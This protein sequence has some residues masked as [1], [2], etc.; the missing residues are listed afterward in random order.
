MNL[1]GRI[2]WET[3]H[4]NCHSEIVVD[5]DYMDGWRAR[6]NL[7]TAIDVWNIQTFVTRGR[8]QQIW[9][10]KTSTYK[11]E[12]RKLGNCL[13]EHDPRECFWEQ[14]QLL[15]KLFQNLSNKVMGLANRSVKWFSITGL[16]VCLPPL[17]LKWSGL[18]GTAIPYCGA[19]SRRSSRGEV[20]QGLIWWIL[21]DTILKFSHFVKAWLSLFFGGGDSV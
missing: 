18:W 19:P 13:H 21:F 12:T 17:N 10:K 11:R 9:V 20:V 2:T 1:A 15:Q 14:L 6:K 8:G 5:Q 7:L 4:I 3:Y 16:V